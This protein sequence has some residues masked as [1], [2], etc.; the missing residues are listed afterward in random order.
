MR[1]PPIPYLHPHKHKQTQE[2]KIIKKNAGPFAK[3]K[4][5]DATRAAHSH[6]KGRK[7]R[8]ERMVAGKPEETGRMLGVKGGE[9]RRGTGCLGTM[10]IKRGE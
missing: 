10:N 8:R 3:I 5:R 1:P 7:R 6:V 2:N 4:D 9:H